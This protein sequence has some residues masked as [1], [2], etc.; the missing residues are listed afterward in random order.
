M[1]RLT[2]L[3]LLAAPA[4]AQTIIPEIYASSYCSLR[5]I[6]VT[7]DDA[8]DLATKRSIDINGTSTRVNVRGRWTDSDIA[9]AIGMVSRSCPQYL[10]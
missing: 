7:R 10:P 8:I 4:H 3:L 1:K 9:E 2:L 6:G 5:N